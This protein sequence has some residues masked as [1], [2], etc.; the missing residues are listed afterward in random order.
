VSEPL[1][2]VEGLR[3]VFRGRGRARPVAAVDGV[4]L[5]LARG[6]TLGLVGESGCG[7]STTAR[8]ILRLMAP[9][10]GRV[11]FGGQDVLAAGRVALK[12]LR[13]RM[14]IVFQNPYASLNARMSVGRMLAEPLAV[15]GRARGREARRRVG[16][17][18]ER[19]GL[20]ADAASRYPH[21]FSG[22][23]RQRIGIA[24]AMMLEPEVVICDEPV[25]ALDVS[26]Q[27]QL[28]NLLKDLQESAGVAYLLIAHDLAV[29]RHVTDRVALM[30]LGRIVETAPTD[31]FFAAP[32]HPYARLLLACVP[33]IDGE[34]IALPDDLPPPAHE[35]RGCAFRARCPEAFVR[36]A[37]EAPALA[38]CG[39]GHRVACWRRD[40]ED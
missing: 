12:A 16:E 5:A 15:H 8:C 19:V 32:R 35:A 29:V 11:R 13:A 18:L 17:A 4:S 6:E 1:L 2:Q 38:P 39:D 33:R 14:Q 3:K 7:K 25:S 31:A 27:A 34:P 9:T 30:Y 23:Q 40:G 24:R 21:E 26:V 22:G 28:L 36:C 37:E 10:A 20:P